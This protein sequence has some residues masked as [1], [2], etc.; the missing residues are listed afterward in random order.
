MTAVALVQARVHSRRLPGKILMDLCGRPL[1]QHVIERASRIPGVD[2]AAI[3]THWDDK[4][5]VQAAV[6]AFQVLAYPIP[7]DDCL[8]RHVWAALDLGATW[9][10]RITSDCPLFD[11]E[12]GGRVLRA[13]IERN[14]YSTNDVSI[15]GDYD[16]TDCQAWPIAALLRESVEATD[17]FDREHPGRWADRQSERVLVCN[18]NAGGP[19][20]PKL[21][22]DTL[23]DLERV[24]QWMERK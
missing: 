8:T 22:V 9:V 11:P 7:E 18:P 3:I 24:R 5:A 14:I 1:L 17:P 21:S 2:R 6:P 23:E 15:S 19:E 4:A 13:A 16:G 20:W 10:A 12:V